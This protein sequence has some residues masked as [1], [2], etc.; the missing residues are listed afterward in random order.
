LRFES[1][2]TW[3]SPCSNLVVERSVPVTL[4]NYIAVKFFSHHRAP[5]G[6]KPAAEGQQHYCLLS[7]AEWNARALLRGDGSDDEIA[8]L[9]LACAPNPRPTASTLPIS[10]APSAPCIKSAADHPPLATAS[11][12]NRLH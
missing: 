2:E 3:N 10:C 7:T 9:A 5:A 12:A 11:D 4:T 6:R 8:D 1:G